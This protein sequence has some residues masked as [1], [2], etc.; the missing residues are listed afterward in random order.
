MK[1]EFYKVLENWQKNDIETPLMV[2]G[3]RQV[4]K[5]YII[6]EF[7]KNN[8]DDYI[9]INLKDNKEVCNIFKEDEDSD[10]I[11]KNLQMYLNR[12]IKENTIIFIDEIQESEE[13]ISALKYFCE[14]EFPYKIIV[15]GSLLGVKL[16]RFSKSFPVGKVLIYHMYPLSFKEFLMALK[17]DEYI[18]LIEKSFQNNK[19]LPEYF[20]KELLDIYRNFLITGGM[21]QMVNDYI[22][23][24][25]EIKENIIL[26]SIIEAYLADMQ[27]HT[28]N[29]SE[30]NK[31]AKMY[32]NIPS[33]LAKENKKY[34]ISKIDK[35]A[36]FRDYESA[37]EWLLASNL[38]IPCYYVNRFETPLKAFMDD[39]NFK[40]YMSDVGLLTENLGIP[41]NNILL[42]NDFMFKG[43]IAENYVATE[44][45]KNN[46]NLFYYQKPQ[47][48]EVDFLIDINAGIIPIE[49]KASDRV[50][51][52]SLNKF[53]KEEKLKLG[54]RISTK[55]FGLENNIK[56]IPLYAVFCIK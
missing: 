39:T 23:N 40:I 46:V 11:V 14:N 51:S 43:A 15:A 47:V 22:N 18:E 3:A 32:L 38:I 54:Y 9:Y 48:M 16:K 5:T 8:F 35:Y 52:T 41:Y 44:L 4:G 42:D 13:A 10:I 34:Q 49:V 45:Q 36:R 12:K 37:M 7:C 53:M 33:Q 25:G 20:H 1:R 27:E 19:P 29:A 31:I 24:K 50:K 17:K 28:K 56:S 2:V 26:K 30:T 6:D 21:P 55:N